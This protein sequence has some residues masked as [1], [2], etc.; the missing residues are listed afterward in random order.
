M[1]MIAFGTFNSSFVPLIEGLCS[2]VCIQNQGTQIFPH[3]V[4]CDQ[5]LA[6]II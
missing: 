1:M 3:L 5:G 6:A 2:S 4:H